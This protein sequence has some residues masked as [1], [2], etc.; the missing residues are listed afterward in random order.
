MSE[1]VTS[2]IAIDL[3]TLPKGWAYMM[4]GDLLESDGLS[5]GVVQPGSVDTEGVPVLRV[6]NVRHGN[7]LT[8]EVTHVSSEIEEKHK[9]TRLRGGEV[10]L[11]LVGSVGEAAVVPSTLAGWNVARAIGVLRPK[12]EVSSHWI[13][14]CLTTELAQHCMRSWQNETVQA[15]LNLRDVRRLPIVMPPVG[16]RQA[17][18]EILIALEDKIAL[19]E[20]LAESTRDLGFANYVAARSAATAVDIVVSEVATVVSRGVTP[21]YSQDANDPLVLNQKCIREGRVN[22][23]PA[24][25]TAAEKV[26]PHKILRQHDVLVNSTG[27]G[28]L[29]RVAIWN[30]RRHSTTDSH[31]TIVRF[32]ETKVDPVCSGFAMLDAQATIEAMGEGSTGQTELS[33]TKLGALKLQL[34]RPADCARLRPKLEALEA[35]G[36]AALVESTALHELREVLLPKLM[37]GQIRVRDAEKAAEEAL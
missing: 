6:R 21:R 22:L 20:R 37:S 26:P 4:L 7:I 16:A 31:V 33:R 2:N 32:D 34:P 5:Y 8:N 13:R 9:R 11:T 36:H 15:T 35:R 27:V 17:I 19:N 30:W 23:T 10:L 28:T 12:A 14:M 1:A 18:E 3:P 29:G 25:R 24:R